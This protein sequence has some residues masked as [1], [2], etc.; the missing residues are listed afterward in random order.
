[1]DIFTNNNLND[2]FMNIVTGIFEADDAPDETPAPTDD[3]TNEP[4]N[5]NVQI[6]PPPEESTV[7]NSD[8][9]L[10]GKVLN[11]YIDNDPAIHNLIEIMT[12]DMLDQDNIKEYVSSFFTRLGINDVDEDKFKMFSDDIWTK[13]DSISQDDP[14]TSLAEFVN[15]V[16]GKISELNG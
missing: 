15:W 9:F 16:H 4:N 10:N 1:M 14:K 11:S 8:I 2:D 3:S 13:L 12:A 7:K 5:S 6:A